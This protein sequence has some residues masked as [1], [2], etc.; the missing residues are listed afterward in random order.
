[1][2]KAGLPLEKFAAGEVIFVEGSQGEKMYGVCVGK[3][4][5]ERQGKVIEELSAGDSFGEMSIDRRRASERHS[6]R[7]DGL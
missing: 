6:S 2:A 3:V 4:T 1:L 7:Q 5:I